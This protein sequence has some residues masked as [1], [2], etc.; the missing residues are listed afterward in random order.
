MIYINNNSIGR[1][2]TT[3]PM[4]IIWRT[5]RILYWEDSISVGYFNVVHNTQLLSTPWKLG[6][7]TNH[8]ALRSK[9][10][11]WRARHRRVLCRASRG[12]RRFPLISRSSQE[13]QC[14]RTELFTWLHQNERKNNRSKKSR[15]LIF[16][17]GYAVWKTKEVSEIVLS[18]WVIT[19]CGSI[20]TVLND[21]RAIFVANGD[22]AIAGVRTFSTFSGTTASF[23]SCCF[24][25]AWKFARRIFKPFVYIILG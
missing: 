16:L 1:Q 8:R 13:K 20:S 9:A 18:P 5:P 15:T 23:S 7:S 19:S 21:E 3:H 22:D 6:S 4:F 24:V 12:R 25:F 10:Y 17:I 14:K 2:A 11:P